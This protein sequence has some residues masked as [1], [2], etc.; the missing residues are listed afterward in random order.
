MTDAELCMIDTNILVYM[1]E[2]SCEAKHE[3]AYEL[4][5]DVM[6]NRI[7]AAVS[8][9]VLSELFVNLTAEKKKT[10]VTSPL[11]V[12]S[13]EVIIKDIA[14]T[15]HFTVFDVKPANVL[16]A[17]QL[18]KSSNISYWDCLIAATMKEN[19]ITKIYTEDKEFEKISEIMV[20]N[21]FERHAKTI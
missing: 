21:P 17:I 15:A 16:G 1:F 3:L 7:S 9:Q 11:D 20:I 8:T 4:L 5:E 12:K 13:A 2:D 14:K 18:K 6:E 10:V 19:S